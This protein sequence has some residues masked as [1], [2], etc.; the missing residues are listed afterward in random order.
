MRYRGRD[1]LEDLLVESNIEGV[2]C[3]ACTFG[4]TTQIRGV[5]AQTNVDNGFVVTYA[6]I[7]GSNSGENGFVL[8][9]AWR[10]ATSR[11]T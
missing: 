7:Q 11:A 4:R 9:A 2:S 3:G 6:L 1:L 10:T 8:T 5:R